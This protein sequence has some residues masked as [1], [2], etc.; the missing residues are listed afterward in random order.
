MPGL[1]EDRE[2]VSWEASLSGCGGAS[3]EETVLGGEM[4]AGKQVLQ[5]RNRR[6]FKVAMREREC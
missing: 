5:R 3:R 6:V 4:V 1:G 2:T